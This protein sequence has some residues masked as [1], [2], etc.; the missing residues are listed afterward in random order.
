MP[1]HYIW[2][3]GNMLLFRA[4]MLLG[5]SFKISYIA[6]FPG[7]FL[8]GASLFNASAF[9][10]NERIIESQLKGGPGLSSLRSFP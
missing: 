6:I 2:L 3:V 1:V 10:R 9:I 4:A 8:A 7:M 5:L